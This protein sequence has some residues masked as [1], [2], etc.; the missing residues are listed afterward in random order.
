MPKTDATLTAILSCFFL[1][2][3]CLTVV[4]AQKGPQSTSGAPLKGVDVKLGR[5]PGGGTA[6]RTTTDGE[7]NF[8]F[9]V[10]PAGEYTLTI[11]QKEASTKDSVLRYCY[12]IV[13]R[14]G[15]QKDIK[16][17]DFTQ[18]KAFDPTIDPAK[19]ATSRIRFETYTVHSD[20]AHPVEG[21]IVKS[22]SNIS[23][24]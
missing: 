12:I 7:G 20:G 13:N 21:T 1:T 14:A 3:L 2:I 15:G 10:M 18:N 5:N 4:E 24:N 23:N 9:P 16:G 8:K 11:E 22:K 6:A 17:Y 19:L